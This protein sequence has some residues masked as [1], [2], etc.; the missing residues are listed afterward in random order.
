MPK[1]IKF[2]LDLDKE[3]FIITCT[4]AEGKKRRYRVITSEGL[5]EYRDARGRS[6]L[7]LMLEEV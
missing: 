6:Y 5:I 7:R 3:E 1:T 2:T 4:D